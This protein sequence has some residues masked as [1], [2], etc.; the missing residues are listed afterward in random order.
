[1]WILTYRF[2]FKVKCRE[3][4]SS[5]GQDSL[6]ALVSLPAAHM[7][8]ICCYWLYIKN[9]TQGSGLHSCRRAET[10]VGSAE[11][12][13]RRSPEAETCLLHADLPVN[14]RDS[15]AWPASTRVNL[16]LNSFTSK[17]P[18]WLGLSKPRLNLSGTETSGNVVSF[19]FFRVNT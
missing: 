7:W 8:P 9:T 4:E 2:L 14:G 11:A 13:G 19:F 1:M 10:G 15:S 18:L 6:L 17:G 16:D 5:Y 12:A 3:N